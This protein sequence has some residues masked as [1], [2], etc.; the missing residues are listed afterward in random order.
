MSPFQTVLV[1]LGIVLVAADIYY[2]KKWI[3]ATREAIEQTRRTLRAMGYT[4]PPDDE[5]E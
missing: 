2:T 1:A 4:E 5:Y 3:K